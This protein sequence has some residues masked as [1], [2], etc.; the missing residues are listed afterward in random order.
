M[1]FEEKEALY[2]GDKLDDYQAA[3]FNSMSFVAAGWGYGD[4]ES[5]HTVFNSPLQLLHFISN[6][7][8]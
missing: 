5:S 2:I 8:G 3:T 4:W 7:N 6:Y 1:L